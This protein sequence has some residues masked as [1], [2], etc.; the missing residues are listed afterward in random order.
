MKPDNMRPSKAK[1]TVRLVIA[2]SEP[3]V[4]DLARP[5]AAWLS[6]RHFGFCLSV[7]IFFYGQIQAFSFCGSTLPVVSCNHVR[8]HI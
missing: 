8:P 5:V 6:T 4:F 1:S 3:G 7:F 2:C